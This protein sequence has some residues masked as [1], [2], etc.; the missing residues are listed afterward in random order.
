MTPPQPHPLPRFLIV[1]AM[2]AGTTTL[3]RDLVRHPDIWM[4]PEKE[5]ETLVRQPDAAA[6]RRD[7]AD[8]FRAAP[9]GAML[10]EASTAYTK[11]PRHAEVAQRA[12]E[13]CGP[14]LR[15]IYLRRDPVKR[16]VSHYRHDATLGLTDLSFDAA[17]RADPDYIAF[18]RYD[19]QIAPWLAVFG[20]RV[21]QLSFEDYIAD[22]PG[23]AA[24]VCAFL[25]LDP[26]RLPPPEVE[27][28]F[29]ASGSR[30]TTRNPL[31]RALVAAPFYQRRVKPLLPQG[32]K[33]RAMAAL[34][35]RARAPQVTLDAATT[36]WLRA[37]LN[38]DPQ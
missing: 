33:A 30:P 21:L 11:R 26:A 28:A 3:Y 22:R 36:A 10:G 14:D 15:V 4:P 2:K 25:G 8:L 19:W 12:L 35:P 37:E 6:A 38:R 17:V 1:G 16:I 18:S 20:D 5:P 7:Y 32:L 24:Q 23:T 29:N 34:L 31:L 27:K 13:V 9:A